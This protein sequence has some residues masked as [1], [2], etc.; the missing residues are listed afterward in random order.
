MRN[1]HPWETV[2]TPQSGDGFL[3]FIAIKDF[4]GVQPIRNSRGE[5]T[6]GM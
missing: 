6:L 5:V 1:I 2:L 4:Y 3:F